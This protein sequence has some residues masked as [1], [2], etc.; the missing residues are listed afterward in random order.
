VTLLNVTLSF[1]GDSIEFSLSEGVEATDKI[2]SAKYKIVAGIATRYGVY[3]SG[4][5]NLSV[6]KV[7]LHT[8][9][10]TGPWT[11]PASCTIFI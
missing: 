5:E 8:H 2:I 4:F 9:I 7:F 3:G 10:Q 1:E 6:Q 11:H